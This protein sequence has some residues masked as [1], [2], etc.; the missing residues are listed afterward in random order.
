M[1]V[2][3]SDVE[4]KCFICHEDLDQFFHEESEEW[5]LKDAVRYEGI[6]YHRLCYRDYLTTGVSSN[7]PHLKIHFT[8]INQ[9]LQAH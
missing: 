6:T 9:L 8:F 5:H 1:P 3:S 2:G 4:N 7:Q